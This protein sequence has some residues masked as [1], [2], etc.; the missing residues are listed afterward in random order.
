M[1]QVHPIPRNTV[2]GLLALAFLSPS[3][4]AQPPDAARVP[5][6]TSLGPVP[7]SGGTRGGSP[8]DVGSLIGGRIGPSVPRGPAGGSPPGLGIGLQPTE[9]FAVPSPAPLT[10]TPTYGPLS[11]PTGK[12]DE[13]PPDGLTLDAAIERLIRENLDLR[14]QFHEIPKAQADILTASLRINPLIYYD[15]QLIPYG[16]YSQAR[17]GGP[18]QHDVNIS[19][20]LDLSRKRQA[21]TAVASRA[22]RVIEAQYQDAVR[23]QIDNLYIVYVDVLT[24]RET[25]RYART[26]IDGLVQLLERTERLRKAGERPQ[27]DVERVRAQLDV[28]RIGLDDA[29]ESFRRA[30]REL[31]PLLRLAPT[32]A[33]SLELRGAIAPDA[34]PP[35]PIEALV[36]QALAYRP[37]LS[38]IRLGIGL[39]EAD[40]KLA[41][42]E[43]Y[44]DVYLLYQ[45]Y[46]FQDMSPFDL[47]S[48]HSWA[49][50]VTVPL[51][52]FNRNQ[53]NIQRSR[54]N[55]A[56]TQTQL[57]AAELRVVTE[58][59]QAAR[60]YAVTRSTVERI[61]RELLPRARKLRDAALDDYNQGEGTLIDYALSQREYNDLVRQYRDTQVRHRRSMLA[62]NTVVGQRIMP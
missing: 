18:V 41:L 9:G 45:P 49:I 1:L 15:T 21:R 12:E 44:Q 50:G 22:R 13:G 32:G 37:D 46:T 10:E 51:P 27:G 40:V 60:E 20:P 56:Q 48:S 43:R 55:V 62:L 14:A 7:G 30:K 6:S 39:A 23:L 47:K 57:G 16:N 11:V 28:A 29:D 33:E 26:S 4:E 61:E 17:P 52:L 34:P 25:V 3:A 36:R 38:A 2:L 54:V 31:A 53:G 58:V 5:E 19:I 35:P 59:T 24:A 42:A 8:A